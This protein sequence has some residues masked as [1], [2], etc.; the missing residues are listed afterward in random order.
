MIVGLFG[1]Q[2]MLELLVLVIECRLK[3]VSLIV[4]MTFRVNIYKRA[5]VRMGRHF[6][7]INNTFHHFL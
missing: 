5:G 7:H 2:M 1:F 3:S 6:M 4:S